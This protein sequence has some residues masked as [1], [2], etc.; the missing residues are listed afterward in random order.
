MAK[1]I[2][3]ILLTLTLLLGITACNGLPFGPDDN[4][5]SAD[6]GNNSTPPNDDGTIEEQPSEDD[7]TDVNPPEDEDPITP[8]DDNTNDDPIN[9]DDGTVTVKYIIVS[10]AKTSY[11]FG[12]EF[13]SSG[14]K[15]TAKMSDGSSKVLS[16]DEYTVVCEGYNSMKTGTYQATVSLKE[17]KNSISYDVTVT[18]AKVEEKK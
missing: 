6:N 4:S 18:P 8:P 11:E 10:G 15:V 5:G 9:P 2:I 3:A 14:I 16:S 17:S 13:T 1:K 7:T 12:D